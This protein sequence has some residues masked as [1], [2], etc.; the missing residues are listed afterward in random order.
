MKTR[1]FLAALI[2]LFAACDSMESNYSDYL[3]EAKQYSPR[4]INLTANVPENGVV[5]LFWDNPTSDTAVK[6]LIDTGDDQ[7]QVEEMISTYRLE[8]LDMKG[9]TIAVYTID[10]TGNYSIP[11]TV[12]IFPRPRDE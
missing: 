2:L 12:Q 4:V 8:G 6:I 1:I 11:A 5:D 7:Y 10:N 3:K 9:Y